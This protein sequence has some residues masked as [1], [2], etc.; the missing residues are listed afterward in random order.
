MSSTRRET[1]PL[2]E[3]IV[4]LLTPSATGSSTDQEPSS[5]DTSPDYP[6]ERLEQ[7]EQGG[8]GATLSNATPSNVAVSFPI[9]PP[10]PAADEHGARTA[11]IAPSVS[12]PTNGASLTNQV[13]VNAV[14]LLPPRLAADD[15]GAQGSSVPNRVAPSVSQPSNGASLTNQAP[16]NAV[17]LLPP[18]LAADDQGAQGSSV[19]DRV[20][21]SVSQPTNGASSIDQAPFRFA[22]DVRGA[23]GSSIANSVSRPSAGHIPRIGSSDV[24]FPGHFRQNESSANTNPPPNPETSMDIDPTLPTSSNPSSTSTFPRFFIPVLSG[25]LFNFTRSDPNQSNQSKAKKRRAAPEDHTTKVQVIEQKDVD[26]AE[27]SKQ[28][29]RYPKS[30]FLIKQ[31]EEVLKKIIDDERAE[32]TKSKNAIKNAEKKAERSKKEVEAVRSQYTKLSKA[33]RTEKESSKGL[34]ETVKT[35]QGDLSSALIKLRRAESL[36]KAYDRQ[37]LEAQERHEKT[38]ADLEAAVASRGQQLFAQISDLENDIACL[39]QE[40]SSEVSTLQRQLQQANSRIE[41]L[42]A[43]QNTAALAQEQISS[44]QQQLRDANSTIENLN[45]SQRAAATLQQ[46]LQQANSRIEDLS[47]SQNTAALAQEQ[48]NSLQQQL[49]DA[50]STIENL[51]ASQRAAATLQQQLQAANSR[52]ESLSASQNTAALAQE[53]I[54]SLQQQLRDANSTIANLNTSQ[55]AA[56]AQDQI[57]ALQQQLERANTTRVED[58]QTITGLNERLRVASNEITRLTAQLQNQREESQKQYHALERDLKSQMDLHQQKSAD[59]ENALKA[60]QTNRMA[61][62]NQ[63]KATYED[64]V[65]SLRLQVSNLAQQCQANQGRLNELESSN[66]EFGNTT[67]ALE[68]ILKNERIKNE[69]NLFPSLSIFDSDHTSKVLQARINSVMKNR[70][71]NTEDD[72]E[73]T[74]IRRLDARRRLIGI[75]KRNAGFSIHSR[76][77]QRGQS[78]VPPSNPPQNE[79]SRDEDDEMVDSSPLRNSPRAPNSSPP[80][81]SDDEHME[82][83]T[84]H[85]RP[86]PRSASPRRYIIPGFFPTR[87]TTIPPSQRRRDS[88]R[89]TPI[90]PTGQSATERYFAAAMQR[91]GRLPASNSTIAPTSATSAVN[92]PY[93]AAYQARHAT[94]PTVSPVVDRTVPAMPTTPTTP[95][96]SAS[97]VRTSNTSVPPNSSTANPQLAAYQVRHANRSGASTNPQLAAYQARHAER[98]GA[99]AQR[100][101]SPATA[102]PAPPMANTPRHPTSTVTA[103]NMPSDDDQHPSPRPNTDNMLIE[104]IQ[105]MTASVNGLRDDLANGRGP[106]V[107]QTPTKVKSPFKEKAPARP[108]TIDRTQLTQA[109]RLHL[110]KCLDLP[111]DHRDSQI[112]SDLDNIHIADEVEVDRLERR[113]R[114]PPTMTPFQLYFDRVN[115]QWN[116]HMANLFADSLVRQYPEYRGQEEEIEQ[117]FLRRLTTLRD[118]M[119]NAMPRGDETEQDAGNRLLM[120]KEGRDRFKRVRRR[121]T[122]LYETR[123]DSAQ[124]ANMP[125]HART[126]VT[127]GDDGMSSDE[128]DSEERGIR[129]VRI[130]YWRNPRLLNTVT[131]ADNA[132]PATTAYGGRRPGGQPDVRQRLR[133]G[134]NYSTRPAPTRLPINYYNP[135]WLNTLSDLELRLLDPQAA[136]PFP[137]EDD[138]VNPAIY[139]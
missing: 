44:L 63:M 51:N 59:A 28:Q 111:A 128:S 6:T 55:S 106:R 82:D 101:K 79:A 76:I 16:V 85:Q 14:I 83:G 96:H 115:T 8:A 125:N 66:T 89:A 133:Q 40:K 25:N 139:T 78:A 72:Y 74:E 67:S 42:S 41:D 119:S 77:A 129:S 46:Q 70:T 98:S 65:S 52:I 58:Q 94:R 126:I 71:H 62:M 92:D 102:Q 60:E 110:R 49:R 39:Q 123:V 47:A 135:V 36:S 17:T 114:D 48:I 11:S 7:V 26:I 108:R 23:Q 31:R 10:G 112:Y 33:M 15:Q 124:Q 32:L 13:P 38:N 29:A 87:Y 64:T 27:L 117:C 86:V 91:L 130:L 113:R 20:A 100:A 24:L 109:V 73:P 136:Q 4:A 22:T 132:L 81:D 84:T 56:H 122:K 45:A 103:P 53:Q 69:V 61:E 5:M 30:T 137:G 54:N 99:S 104:C 138:E 34:E 50:N 97:E 121:Q 90:P 19:P 57:N 12:Q 37:R 107:R 93:R 120:E 88:N 3:R 118:Y 134:Q 127:L 21:P 68:D 131:D 2:K 105:T 80:L 18:R 43:S 116:R 75:N 35:Q 1:L 9:P 95:R